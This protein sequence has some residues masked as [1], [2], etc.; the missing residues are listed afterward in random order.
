MA[1]GATQY[2]QGIDKFGCDKTAPNRKDVNKYKKFVIKTKD[3]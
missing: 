1:F 3:E 2:L